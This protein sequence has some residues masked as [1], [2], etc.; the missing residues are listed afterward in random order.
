MAKFISKPV[1]IEAE[2]FTPGHRPPGVK[3][4]AR[5]F[6]VRTI[7]GDVFAKHGDWIIK[8]PIGPGFYPC[9]D[10]VFKAKCEPKVENPIRDG[11]LAEYDASPEIQAMPAEARAIRRDLIELCFKYDLIGIR[12][13]T[14]KRTDQDNQYLLNLVGGPIVPDSN[15]G[16]YFWMNYC[17]TALFNYMT[18]SL[19]G[20]AA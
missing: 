14:A 6:F 5:G 7:Q 1:E 15:A 8:E 20:G 12:A 10:D 16:F 11:L 9:A 19:K 13:F 2:Q 3:E 4:E 18:Q 17:C